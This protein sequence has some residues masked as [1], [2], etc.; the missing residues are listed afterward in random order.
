MNANNS[1][2]P[3]SEGKPLPTDRP[4]NTP[5]MEAKDNKEGIGA[6]AGGLDALQRL[7]PGL[8]VGVGMADAAVQQMAP[9]YRRLCHC[10]GR[11]LRR[12]VRSRSGEGFD[13]DFAYERSETCPKPTS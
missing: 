4:G 9:K 7:L 13:F 5:S 10:V 2:N 6:S 3:G 11:W 8:P 1:R 12:T